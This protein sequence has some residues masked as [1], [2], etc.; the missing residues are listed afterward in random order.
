MPAGLGYRGIPGPAQGS[1]SLVSSLPS[2]S[3]TARK[4]QIYP[5]PRSSPPL[6]SPVTVTV[7]S[8][9]ADVPGSGPSGTSIHCRAPLICTS[10]WY[11]M[12]DAA[13]RTGV[14]HVSVICPS[15]STA[16]T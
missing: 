3:R 4:W 9:L 1:S 16:R 6:E 13:F 14:P 7:R 5:R 12:T 8:S 2:T 15:P 11:L 10:Y